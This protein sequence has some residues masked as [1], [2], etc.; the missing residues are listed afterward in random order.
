LK[1]EKINLNTFKNTNVVIS[2]QEF[3]FFIVNLFNSLISEINDFE[4]EVLAILITLFYYEKYLNNNEYTLDENNKYFLINPIWFKHF[5]EIYNYS[6][7]SQILSNYNKK[8]SFNTYE[9]C[10]ENIIDLLFKKNNFKF[11]KIDLYENLSNINIIAAS[12]KEIQSIIYYNNCNIIPYK[13]INMINKTFFKNNDNKFGYNIVLNKNKS[14]FIIINNIINVGYFNQ[15]LLFI[16]KFAFSYI[17]KNILNEKIKILNSISIQKI[18]DK[19]KDDISS[20][21]DIQ[22]LNNENFNIGK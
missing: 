2:F 12:Q 1:K 10:I 3:N 19:D 11:E 7:V 16:T 17:N 14:I 8:I 4:K 13:V 21:D 9:Q 20:S 15:E 18:I 6:S 22:I 5:K